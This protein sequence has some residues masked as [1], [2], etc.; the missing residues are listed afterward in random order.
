LVPTAGAVE[1]GSDLW[2]PVHLVDGD[3][4]PVTAVTAFLSE[5]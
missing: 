4:E 1:V 5:L 2:E 3:G